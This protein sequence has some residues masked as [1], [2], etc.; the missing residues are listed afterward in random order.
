[1]HFNFLNIKFGD[2]L[3][4][5]KTKHD[6]VKIIIQNVIFVTKIVRRRQ[7]MHVGHPHKYP[8]FIIYT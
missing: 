2:R 4:L 6:T 1:M 3:I 7:R 8:H 5:F